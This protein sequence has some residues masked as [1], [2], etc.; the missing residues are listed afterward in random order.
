MLPLRLESRAPALPPNRLARRLAPARQQGV[1][2]V[3]VLMLMLALMGI[4]AFSARNANFGEISSRN[5]L[6]GEIARQAAESAMRDAERDLLLSDGSVLQGTAKCKREGARPLESAIAGFS[7]TCVGGQC[8]KSL[9]D[10]KTTSWVASS[11]NAE[12]WW[13]TAKGGLWGDPTTKPQTVNAASCATFTG[14]VPIGLYTGAPAVPGVAIQPEY[15]I[16]QFSR[17]GGRIIYYRITA[18]GFGVSDRT[19]VVLQ[20]YFQPFTIK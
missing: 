6:D 13:P 3:V 4:V 5:Q 7:A 9:N 15:L 16:E 12:P 11:T 17:S 19:Q 14:G 1:A 2:M 8:D 10:Y 20:S 18:R